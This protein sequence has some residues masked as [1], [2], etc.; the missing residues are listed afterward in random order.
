[1]SCPAERDVF[2]IGAIE[3]NFPPFT[4]GDPRRSAL[5]LARDGNREGKRKAPAVSGAARVGAVP[6]YTIGGV[7]GRFLRPR[8]SIRTNMERV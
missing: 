6:S 3:E 4:V 2:L 8:H 5:G 1:M 7:G